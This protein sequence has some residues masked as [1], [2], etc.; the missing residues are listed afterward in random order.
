MPFKKW[1]SDKLRRIAMEN[2]FKSKQIKA[3][4]GPDSDDYIFTFDELIC[5][6]KKASMEC[7]QR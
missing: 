6:L 3:L 5:E 1:E 4:G 2:T 7:V